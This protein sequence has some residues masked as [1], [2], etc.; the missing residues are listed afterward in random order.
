MKIIISPYTVFLFLLILIGCTENTAIMPSTAPVLI[1]TS[2]LPEED[3]TSSPDN[4]QVP[5]AIITSSPST[6]F[7]L[8][9]KGRIA[10]IGPSRSESSIR[11]IELEN[12]SENGV[13]GM[14]HGSLSWSPDGQWIAFD[15]GEPLS[16][17]T[18]IFIIRPNGSDLKQLTNNLIGESHLDWSPNGKSL[19]FTYDNHVQPT[20]LA[21]INVENN[22]LTLITNTEGYESH[23]S[24]SPDSNQ[25]AYLYADNNNSP[26]ELWI[27]DSDGKNSRRV[28]DHPIAFGRL[29]WSPDGEYIAFI[30]GDISE[31]CGE[32]Y[33]VRPNGSDLS[34]LTNLSNCATGLIWSPDGK[35]IAF[36]SRNLTTTSDWQ[37]HIINIEDGSVALITKNSDLPINDIDWAQTPLAY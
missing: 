6:S 15:G 9:I 4:F 17:Q 34:R 19:V 22:S 24:W 10:L 28:I 12:D 29:S 14:G 33:M 3:I 2:M 18:D 30:S 35:Y 31:D 20:D 7:E 27:M 13:T 26:L 25:I 21:L 11:V 1:S 37:I 32:I 8:V 5:T 16:Q 36:I 23:P